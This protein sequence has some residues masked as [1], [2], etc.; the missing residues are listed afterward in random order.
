MEV[1]TNTFRL[2]SKASASKGESHSVAWQNQSGSPGAAK[3]IPVL[4]RS[5]FVERDRA[6]DVAPALSVVIPV[7]NEQA[8]LPEFHRRLATVL[9]ELGGSSEILY[10]ND[11]STDASFTILNGIREADYRVALINLSRNFGKEIAVTAGLDHVRND[12]VVVIDADLQD[13]PELIPRLIEK[14]QEGFDMVYA[15]RR[16]RRGETLMKRATANIFYRLVRRISD[17]PIPENTGD[18]RVLNRRCLEALKRC[19]E[20]R[21]FMKGL[22]SWVG[23]KH[24]YIVYD[25]DPRFAG[26]TKWNYWRLWDF[27][28][29]GITSC[30]IVPLKLAGYLGTLTA[31]GALAYG[32]FILA[33]TLILGREVA[34]YASLMVTMLFVAGVQ[35]I[36]L[37]VIGEYV[38]R[39]FVE[40]KGRPLYFL[41]AYLPAGAE[42]SDFMQ[43]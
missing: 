39:I 38:G 17:I 25:R 37:G 28:L 24:S 2:S 32:F 31:G 34:G 14:S 30:T 7:Y 23:F 33:R 27:A 13:P 22:F 42:D 3:A 36:A 26:K 6:A 8:V 12:W 16:E 20:R 29:E 11:G 10:I 5:G 4:E 18:F 21:R 40:T 41:D 15:K 43:K 35:L 1:Q 19:G 9:T